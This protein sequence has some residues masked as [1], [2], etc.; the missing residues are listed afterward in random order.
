MAYGRNNIVIDYNQLLLK[1]MDKNIKNK[2]TRKEL[3][4]LEQLQNWYFT[5][6]KSEVEQ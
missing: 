1:L 2:L 6:L 3:Q 5:N 4:Q